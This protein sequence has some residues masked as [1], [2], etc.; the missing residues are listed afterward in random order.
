MPNTIN[1]TKT[2]A[3]FELD[4]NHPDVVSMMNDPNVNLDPDYNKTN[5][6]FQVLIRKSNGSEILLREMLP[7]D[8]LVLRYTRLSAD[9]GN[10][11]YTGVDVLS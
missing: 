6:S 10:N 3:Q 4:L 11:T 2:T 7:T 5:Q 8:I 1:N 9:V